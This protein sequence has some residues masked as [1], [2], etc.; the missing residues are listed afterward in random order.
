LE[1]LAV[2]YARTGRVAEAR[3]LAEPWGRRM[4]TTFGL[5]TSALPDLHTASGVEAVALL[6][7]GG[8]RASMNRAA[9]DKDVLDADRLAPESALCRYLAGSVLKRAQ[10]Y[11]AAITRFESL[12]GLGDARFNAKAAELL[13][14]SR[15]GKRMRVRRALRAGT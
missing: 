15:M 3:A 6:A 7:R 8:D 10:D 13:D 12:Q 5:P 11:D 1:N 14:R 2:A 9:G 4:L